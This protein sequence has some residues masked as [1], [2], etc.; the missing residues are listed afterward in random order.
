M[1]KEKVKTS[2]NREKEGHLKEVRAAV[3]NPVNLKSCYMPLRE[4]KK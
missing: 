1:L 2:T 4:R 3:L